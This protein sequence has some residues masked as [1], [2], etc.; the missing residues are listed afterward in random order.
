MQPLLAVKLV[1]LLVYCRV[2]TLA[3]VHSWTS[4]LQLSRVDPFTAR[5]TGGALPSELWIISGYIE[6]LSRFAPWKNRCLPAAVATAI[7]LRRRGFQSLLVLGVRWHGVGG[8]ALE[9][10]I[11]AHAWLYVGNSVVCGRDGINGHTVLA[12]WLV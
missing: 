1:G 3:P 7:E 6:R 2:L 8:R 10:P 11:D 5:P 4:W 12:A 9:R